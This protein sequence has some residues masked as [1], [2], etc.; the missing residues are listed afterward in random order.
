MTIYAPDNWIV[1]CMHVPE[2]KHYRVLGS[3]YGGYVGS[4]SWKINSGVVKCEQEGDIFLFYGESG[5]IYHCHKNS[6]KVTRMMS[7]PLR[8]F[9]AQHVDAEIMHPDTNWVEM[10]WR[11]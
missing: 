2:D 9:E 4:D 1:L 5:S 3:W 8:M 6:Y 10:K 11:F 7:I